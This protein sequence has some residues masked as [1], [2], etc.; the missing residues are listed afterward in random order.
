MSEWRIE[1]TDPP[2]EGRVVLT[3][4]DDNKGARNVQ[5]LKRGTGKANGLY[6]YP[7]DSMYVYYA[8]THWRECEQ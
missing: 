8:P 1:Q 6:F 3:K 5:K 4:I 7:D 2:P